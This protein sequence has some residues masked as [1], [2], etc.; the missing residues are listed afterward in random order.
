MAEAFGIATAA[1]G[2]L[3]LCRDGFRLVQ[4]VV[5]ASDAFKEVSWRVQSQ[6]NVFE[7]W[8][9]PWD[10]DGYEWGKFKEYSKE[11]HSEALAIGHELALL[12]FT[13]CNA[14]KLLSKYGLKL[15]DRHRHEQ[16]KPAEIPS[17]D[18]KK[19]LTSEA[20]FKK[21]VNGCKK[22]L[23]FIQKC[24]FVL[25]SDNSN[26]DTL[27]DRLRECNEALHRFSP[28]AIQVI[29]T[30]NIYFV[31]GKSASE[32]QVKA[33]FVEVNRAKKSNQQSLPYQEFARIAEFSNAVK[34]QKLVAKGQKRSRE[35]RR[36][37]LSDFQTDPD[38]KV[39]GSQDAEMGLLKKFPFPKEMRVVYIEWMSGGREVEREA[40]AK[41]KARML[42]VKMSEQVLLPTCYGILEDNSG[43]SKRFGL[44]MAPPDHIRLNL[45]FMMPGNIRPGSIMFFPTSSE[46][47]SS[48][49]S[50]TP[51]L[52]YSKPF[53]VGFGHARIDDRRLGRE[54]PTRTQAPGEITLDEYQHPKKIE[55]PLTKYSRFF[56]VYSVGCVLLEIGMWQPLSE[57]VVIPRRGRPAE[58]NRAREDMKAKA[59]SLIGVTGSVYAA[60]IKKCL[61]VDPHSDLSEEKNND[62][63]AA[64]LSELI[65]ELGKCSA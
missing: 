43:Y 30:Q 40:K 50:S 33:L 4:D 20:S 45:K 34:D 15:K 5:G 41:A 53:L 9:R 21:W 8:R 32:E 61:D 39:S 27:V 63:C 57:L 12:S 60:V 58:A 62:V 28:P 64:L 17:P 55:A 26:A 35:V 31:F 47:R 46:V 6:I 49:I 59:E 1:V 38:Y 11:N 22:N 16:I 13:L 2:L 37:E 10:L 14:S 48:R 56:D 24:R 23:P 7:A 18:M 42:S 3:P 44:V 54:D 52:D 19:L 65:G 51:R 36:F 29:Q 25:T